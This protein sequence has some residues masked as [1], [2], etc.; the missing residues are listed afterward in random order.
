MHAVYDSIA[1]V[2][3]RV[4]LLSSSPAYAT[5]RRLHL[6]ACMCVTDIDARVRSARVR[7]IQT[8]HP[9]DTAGAA[10]TACM[11]GKVQLNAAYVKAR[12]TECCGMYMQALGSSKIISERD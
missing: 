7:L 8:V 3:S 4:R 6:H 10:K 1:S 2:G 5:K 12:A 9:R 11:C